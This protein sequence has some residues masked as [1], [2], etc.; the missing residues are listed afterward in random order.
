LRAQETSVI[1]ILA[2]GPD[3]TALQQILSNSAQVTSTPSGI[4]IEV[5]DERQVDE[6]LSALRKLNGKLISVQPVRQSL[7]DL[8]LG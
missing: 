4:R 3:T 1:E 7:E 6:V 5:G 2:A 8:F